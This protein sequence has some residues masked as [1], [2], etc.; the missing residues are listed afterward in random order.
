MIIKQYNTVL[1]YTEM[2]PPSLVAQTC[3]FIDF[4]FF[5]VNFVI[6]RIKKKKHLS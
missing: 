5:H 4:M 1:P 3:Y 2:D 6:F